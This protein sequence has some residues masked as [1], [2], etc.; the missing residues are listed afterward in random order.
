M[1]NKVVTPNPFGKLTLDQLE[2][3]EKKLGVILPEQYRNYLILFNGGK[4]EKDITKI[5]AKEGDTRIHHM[6]GLHAGPGYR[7]L[8]ADIINHEY[9]AICDDAFGNEFLIKVNGV[10]YGGIYFLNHES[11]DKSALTYVAP[12]FSVFVD[13][14]LSRDEDMAEFQ[15]RDPDGYA[16]FQKQ[17][18]EMKR[19]REKDLKK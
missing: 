8:E 3:Y 6:Y 2:A 17:L 16:K 18:E 4:Y 10:G 14:M 12:D 19:L 7:R 1:V 15:A 11:Q 13:N 9:L 5:S